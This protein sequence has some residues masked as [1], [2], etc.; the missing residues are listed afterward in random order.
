MVFIAASA[1]FPFFNQD[2]TSEVVA[3]GLRSFNMGRGVNVRIFD[4]ARIKEK[5]LEENGKLILLTPRNDDK[6]ITITPISDHSDVKV[7]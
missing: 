3:M 2:V 7:W 1:M 4:S 5:D 6:K